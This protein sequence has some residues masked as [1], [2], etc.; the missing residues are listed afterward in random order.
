MV[1]IGL[2]VKIPPHPPPPQKKRKKEENGHSST[3]DLHILK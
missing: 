3:Y 2:R 1:K